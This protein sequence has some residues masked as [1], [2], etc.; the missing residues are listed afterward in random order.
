MIVIKNVYGGS[1]VYIKNVFANAE[2]LVVVY[3]GGDPIEITGGGGGSGDVVGPASA[4]DNAIVRFNLTTGKLIQNSGASVDDSGNITATNLSGTNTGD[5]DL[6]GKADVS[7]T[8]VIADI[9]DFG[10]YAPAL[11]VDDNYVTDAEKTKLANLSG[12]NTGDQDLSG[13]QDVLVS[14]TNIKTVNSSS[15]LGSGNLVISGGITDDIAILRNQAL[16]SDL[17]AETFDINMINTSSIRAGSDL[18]IDYYAIYIPTA[19]TITGAHW[20]Q[21]TA[22][23]YTGADYNGIG[24]YS[25]SGGTLTLVASTTND[26]EIWKA[27]TGSVG[28]KAFSSTYAASAGVYYIAWLYNQSA[29]T[30]A[31]VLGAKPNLT[32]GTQGIFTDSAA[33]AYT[34]T[35]QT[36]LPASVATTSLAVSATVAWIGLY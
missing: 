6:S 7:H 21:A 12:T 30:T 34:Q 17:K 9:T 10:S 8:H 5:Q 2:N 26:S 33:L 24:L 29:Q 27:T 13:K 16:G 28:T 36:S 22:G 3:N 35:L 25:Y 15:L 11:G 23:N 20:I 14:G 19:Q 31:P 32:T 18:R 4:T 1:Q